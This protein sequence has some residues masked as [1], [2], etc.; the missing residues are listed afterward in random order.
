MA[1]KIGACVDQSLLY[2]AIFTKKN[3]TTHYKTILLYNM[4][5]KI[6]K[7][8]KILSAKDNGVVFTDAFWLNK[9]HL[10]ITVNIE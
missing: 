4:D 6:L 7:K 3:G 5:E 2:Y 8:Q 1:I 10:K 9:Y